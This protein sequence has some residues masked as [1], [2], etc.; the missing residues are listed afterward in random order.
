MK[1]IITVNAA[2]THSTSV[3]FQTLY[4]LRDSTSDT[5]AANIL[6][7][8]DGGYVTAGYASNFGA[9]GDEVS[10]I[11]LIST[12]DTSWV[13]VYGVT[14]NV[15]STDAKVII[16]SDGGYA[17]AGVTQSFNGKNAFLIK[18]NGNGNQSWAKIYGSGTGSSDA[19]ISSLV[20]SFDSGFV[21]TGYISNYGAG[22]DD[23]Y[24][25]KT[26]ASGDIAWTKT[27]GGT[28]ADDAYSVA[29][30]ADGGYVVAGATSSFADTLGDVYLIKTDA[31]GDTYGHGHTGVTYQMLWIRPIQCSNPVTMDAL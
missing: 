19:F 30:T 4:G 25:V 3:T 9:G 2:S 7:T 20:Q 13:R 16:T 28:N 24:L 31:N 10:F 14:L 17:I 21:M 23:Y 26:N 8:N 12:G 15:L 5:W 29:A 1:G 11:K 18:T 27:Y 22:S 6:Q